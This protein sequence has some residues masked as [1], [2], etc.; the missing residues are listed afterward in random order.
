M[1]ANTMTQ[2]T[3]GKSPCGC[4]GS[5]AAPSSCGC[6]GKCGGSGQCSCSCGTCSCPSQVY[7]RP[8]FFAGQLLTEDDLQSLVDYVVGKNR[9]HN[10]HLFGDGVV[11]G[12]T[13]TCP[14]C[15]TGHVVV[16]PGYALDC[17]GNDIVVT[18]P[19]DLDINQMV[20]QLLLQQRN[21]D[22]GDPCADVTAATQSGATRTA[23]AAANGNSSK[24]T[25]TARR[26]C[27]YVD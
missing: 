18:C 27:L 22:C 12:L 14:P 15:E 3:A 1:T 26:Y 10:R 19:K 2:T 23:A 21:G 5:G 9:L 24:K 11:C 16:N 6:G 17:C 13:V 8:Q 20:R 4:A 25:S 7:A